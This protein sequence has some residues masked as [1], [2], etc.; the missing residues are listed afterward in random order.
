MGLGVVDEEAETVME[1]GC[2]VVFRCPTDSGRRRTKGLLL[3]TGSGR[4][5]T[6][7][8]SVVSRG[9]R[10]KE[11]GKEEGKEKENDFFF[12]SNL[13]KEEESHHRPFQGG[14]VLVCVLA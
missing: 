7:G 12:F 4:R 2:V 8:T 3:S 10:M 14:V 1:D 5:R 6:R 9:Q 11:D 13:G